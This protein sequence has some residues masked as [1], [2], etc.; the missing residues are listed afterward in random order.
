MRKRKEIKREGGG[1]KKKG[2]N[3]KEMYIHL[4]FFSRSFSFILYFRKKRANKRKEKR[5]RLPPLLF[6]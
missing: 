1:R 3:A 5:N 4:S 6:R 2:N